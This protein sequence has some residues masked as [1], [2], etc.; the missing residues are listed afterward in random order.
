MKT[1]ATLGV[2]F[3]IQKYSTVYLCGKFW[4][5][6]K[7]ERKICQTFEAGSFKAGKQHAT[8]W[9]G[10]K[11]LHTCAH[12][13]YFSIVLHVL[14]KSSLC[15]T[16]VWF[17]KVSLAGRGVIKVKLF[18]NKTGILLGVVGW[19]FCGEGMDIFLELD[20]LWW[21]HGPT[22]KCCNTVVVHESL[23]YYY[24]MLLKRFWYNVMFF[25]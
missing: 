2:H 9:R 5:S 14:Q 19:D 24:L 10:T 21:I 22:L 20:I 23:Q 4:Y 12:S 7:N 8:L 16:I 6:G 18:R 11:L 17:Q 13:Y 25:W 15:S 1:S 3:N